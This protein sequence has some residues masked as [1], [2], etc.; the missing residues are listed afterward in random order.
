MS[1][2]WVLYAGIAVWLGLGAYAVFIALGQHSLKRRVEQLEL[3]I[4][5]E[6]G[7]NR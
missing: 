1:D 4:R 5:R 2:P 6:V 3:I 7:K